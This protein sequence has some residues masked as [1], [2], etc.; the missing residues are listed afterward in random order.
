[1]AAAKLGRKPQEIGSFWVLQ[2]HGEER[3]LEERQNGSPNPLSFIHRNL[4]ITATITV[5]ADI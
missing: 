3:E 5:F 1:M 4:S 2:I